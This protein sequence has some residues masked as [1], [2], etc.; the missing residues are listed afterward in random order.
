VSPGE[1]PA[2]RCVP[3]C[4]Y[5]D[6]FI[7]CEDIRLGILRGIE[8]LLDEFFVD[9]HRR[10]SGPRESIGMCQRCIML[11]DVMPSQVSEIDFEMAA[12]LEGAPKAQQDCQRQ[13]DVI[14]FPENTDKLKCGDV[15][16]IM[17]PGEYVSR[18]CKVQHMPE[19]RTGWSDS[20]GH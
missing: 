5:R 17:W 3:V 2:K 19:E 13:G 14:V 4:P 20:R 1:G 11:Y 12:A 15:A 10:I 6:E 9:L 7:E 16:S 8:H 18:Y